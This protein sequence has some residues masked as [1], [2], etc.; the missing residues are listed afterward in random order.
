MLRHWV[1]RR[2][3]QEVA[4][5]MHSCFGPLEQWLDRQIDRRLVRT[6]SLALVA[7]VRLR[8]SRSGLL[9]DEL[10]RPCPLSG[11]A[12]GGDQAAQQSDALL[13]VVPHSP[14]GVPVVAGRPTTCPIGG[15]EGVGPGHLGRRRAGEA[16]KHRPGGSVPGTL[17][18]VSPSQAHQARLLQSTGRAAGIRPRPAMAYR[19][20]GWDA[21]ASCP[22]RHAL[23]D[24]P[25]PDVQPPAGTDRVPAIPMR[26]AVAKAGGSRLRPGICR[27]ILPWGTGRTSSAVHRTLAHPLS[28]DRRKG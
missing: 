25:G 13:Q 1:G 21:R 7:I 17:Q 28:P 11:S 20:G 5:L 27:R 10:G 19:H 14:G 18:Q 8:H 9:L 22:G 23:M 12:P 6:F 26:P 4:N 3:G 24:Q 2:Q 16:G 15:P